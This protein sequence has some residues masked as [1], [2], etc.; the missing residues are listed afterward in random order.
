LTGNT[1]PQDPTELQ[2]EGDR[3]FA[4]RMSVERTSPPT[5]VTGYEIQRFLGAG[6]Y[7]EVWVGVD[8]NTGRKV[9][10]K[11]FTG[12]HRIDVASLSREVE[13]L[14]F[15]SADRYVVQLLDVGW[16]STPPYY[17]MDYIERGS[18][19][20]FLSNHGSLNAHDALELFRE[21]A[22]GLSHLHNR[23]VLHCDLKPANILLDE[24][25]KPRL[26]DFGQA[27]LATEQNPALGTLFFM[28]PEQADLQAVP[29][30]R[31]D[32]Y[33]LGAIMYCMLVGSPPY[34]NKLALSEVESGDSLEERLER[35]RRVINQA[36]RPSEH[37]RIPNVDRGLAELIDRCLALNP[38]DRFESVQSVLVA[39]EQLEESRSRQSLRMLGLVGPMALLIVMMLFSWGL[40]Q[41]SVVR[42]D[43]ALKLKSQESNSWAAQFAARSA[44]ERINMFFDTVSRLARDETFLQTF[45]Q[46]IEDQKELKEVTDI[47]NQPSNNGS[48][49]PKVVAARQAYIELQQRQ[50][51]Q[52]WIDELL[53]RTDLPEVA[54]WFVCDAQGLQVASAFTAK[55]A[56]STVGKNYSYRTYFT[57][58]PDDLVTY[59]DRLATYDVP[60]VDQRR[61][62]I[63]DAHLSAAFASQ[64]T[65]TWKIAFSVPVYRT[66]E[67]LG[68]LAATVDMGNFVEFSN[69]S[70]HFVMLVDGRPGRN[71]G[72]ILEHPL[73]D[74]LRS[75]GQLL[76]ED[77]RQVRIAADILSAER[78]E[79][80]DPFALTSVQFVGDTSDQRTWLAA[81]SPVQRRVDPTNR[82]EELNRTSTGLWVFA[83][84]DADPILQPV[85]ELSREIARLGMLAMGFGLCIILGMWW[86]TIRS[87]NRARNRLNR[88]LLPSSNRRSSTNPSRVS[89]TE[90]A[91]NLDQKTD[92]N[93]SPT[94]RV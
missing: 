44:A 49:A 70:G 48:Q 81:R 74:Q 55:E 5:I 53:L 72:A 47:L 73:F 40:Y 17:V 3:Q 16:D 89:S 91:A 85:R 10:I 86:M 12:R 35:Y 2:N 9:A 60:D 58:G 82:K 76:P 30:T 84:E 54:S 11:F 64:A 65:G 90:D 43:E 62:H 20:D 71:Q 31:W 8:Q 80:Q 39:I 68:I 1:M 61:K 75:Q 41:N 36:E 33:G 45:E 77:L 32:V 24:D 66:G 67:F 87:W 50:A 4:Q 57:G 46:L 13:K 7:G 79:I 92:A 37:R 52:D 27:R 34:R 93:D 42:T 18:L 83:L 15:L 69:E 63:E 94:S 21:I 6:A 23:G 78:S 19:D 59:R 56:Q 38:R 28:A 14:V 26:A 88:V 51:L 25:R 29:D 22:I